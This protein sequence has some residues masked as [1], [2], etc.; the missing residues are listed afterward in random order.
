VTEL[1]RHD[2]DRWRE[3]AVPAVREPTVPEGVA[4]IQIWA[5][6]AQA[7]SELVERLVDSPFVPDAFRPRIDPRAT[8]EQRHEARQVAIATATAA[9]LYG[10]EIGLSPMQALANVIVIKG[11]PSLYAETMVALVQAAGHEIWTEDVT[12]ARAIV[13]GRRVGSQHIERVVFTIE[14]ARKAGYTAQN[15]KYQEDPQSMLYARAASIACRRT[16][17]EVLKGIPVVEEL[18][19]EDDG[20][21]SAPAARTAQRATRPRSVAVRALPAP[22]VAA[23]PEAA[24]PPPLPGEDGYDQPAE[25]AVEGITAAQQKKLHATLGELNCGERAR[26]LKVIS[27]IVG[28]PIGSSKELSKDDAT[29][30]IDTLSQMTPEGA[31]ALIEGDDDDAIEPSD[32]D[33]AAMNAEAAADAAENDAR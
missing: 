31:L 6:T 13:C 32:E 1:E 18:W 21:V 24:G 23:P 15:K 30:L 26:G 27:V 5:R 17:P 2:P 8:L 33:I 16:A 19:D 11:K 9:V 14:R 3:A 28:R 7:A 10:G 22:A 29:V 25:P 4:A 20:T 12:D